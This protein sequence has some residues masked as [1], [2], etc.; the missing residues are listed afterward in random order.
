MAETLRQIIIWD[1]SNSLWWDYIDQ[2]Y[3]NCV[4]NVP[5]A[6]FDTSKIQRCS[7]NSLIMAGFNEDLRQQLKNELNG[8]FSGSRKEVDNNIYLSEERQAFLREQIN[9]HPTILVNKKP[10]PIEQ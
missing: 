3:H 2:F 7:E 5:D 4:R 9:S 10:Q 8:S 1:L 6:F